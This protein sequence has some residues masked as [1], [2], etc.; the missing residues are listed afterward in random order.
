M[1]SNAWQQMATQAGKQDLAIRST[2][3]IGSRL[4]ETLAAVTQTKLAMGKKKRSTQASA[5]LAKTKAMYKEFPQTIT[6][7]EPTGKPLSQQK[8]EAYG[9]KGT[10]AQREETRLGGQKLFKEVDASTLKVSEDKGWKFW[11]KQKYRDINPAVVEYSQS[12]DD[13]SDLSAFFNNFDAIEQQLGAKD[14]DAFYDYLQE[15]VIPY[16]T[17]EQEDLLKENH[18]D[19][20]E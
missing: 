13:F 1:A 19:Y 15:E 12:M 3:N 2:G 20:F 14:M 11:Q 8:M 6:G 9:S 4:K 18:P 10:A 16:L 17:Q 5:D 7:E